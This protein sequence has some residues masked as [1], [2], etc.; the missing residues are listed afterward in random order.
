MHF[1]R[2]LEKNLENVDHPLCKSLKT[3]IIINRFSDLCSLTKTIESSEIRNSVL[4]IEDINNDD[5][6]FN[7]NSIIFNEFVSLCLKYNLYF[8]FI[9][10]QI[11]NIMHFQGS[12]IKQQT[13][14]TLN[15]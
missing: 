7:P 4:I 9:Y 12:E 3:N 10:E 5:K 1:I 2:N 15:I 13:I 8:I 6:D 11:Q 14:K